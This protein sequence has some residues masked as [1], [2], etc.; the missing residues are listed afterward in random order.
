M[1]RVI[2]IKVAMQCAMVAR[3]IYLTYMCLYMHTLC[4]FVHLFACFD[5]CWSKMKRPPERRGSKGSTRSSWSPGGG[6]ARCWAQGPCS[7]RREAG[8]R[9]TPPLHGLVE[10]EQ[11][12]AARRR[13]RESQRRWRARGGDGDRER[14]GNIERCIVGGE[15]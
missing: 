15:R 2:C 7:P 14:T 1:I 11:G 3:Y 5:T 8:S 4:K 9:L 10:L 13:S 12:S 6:A